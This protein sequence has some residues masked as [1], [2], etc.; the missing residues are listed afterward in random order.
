MKKRANR[1]NAWVEKAYRETCNGVQINVMDI[2][3]VFAEGNRLLAEGADWEQLK[4]GIRTYVD[5]I[6]QN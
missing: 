6:R 1:V 5:S 4:L 2:S 3:K